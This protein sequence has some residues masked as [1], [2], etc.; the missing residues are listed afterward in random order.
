MAKDPP[1]AFKNA[2]KRWRAERGI[3]YEPD[4]P[5]PRSS[6]PT[7]FAV[8]ARPWFVR[9]LI[10]AAVAAATWAAKHWGG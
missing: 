7:L 1:D 6:I 2:E 9:A 3:R 8:K 10:A 5:R 4:E